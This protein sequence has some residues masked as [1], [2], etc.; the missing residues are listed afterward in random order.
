MPIIQETYIINMYLINPRH[1]HGLHKYLACD[2]PMFIFYYPNNI[3]TQY[4]AWIDQSQQSYTRF[5]SQTPLG[6]IIM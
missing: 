5:T 4:I 6:K 3:E 2:V 1:A